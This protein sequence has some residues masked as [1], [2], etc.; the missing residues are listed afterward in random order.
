MSEGL[1]FWIVMFKRKP[2]TYLLRAVIERSVIDTVDLTI[3]APDEHTAYSIAR[4]VLDKF[5]EPHGEEGVPSCYVRE[6]EYSRPEL[7]SLLEQED[8]GTA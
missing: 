7:L 3:H 1:R 4:Q 5:P 6:R 2:K 8:E